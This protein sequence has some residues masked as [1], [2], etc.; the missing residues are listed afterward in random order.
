LQPED[1]E[2]T[3]Q[4]GYSPSLKWLFVRLVLV[5]ASL[6]GTAR[7]LELLNEAFGWGVR[8]PHWTTGRLWLLRVGHAVLT[9]AKVVAADWAWL[10]DHSVQIGP[11]K[12]LVIVGLRLQDLPPA[13]QPLRHTDLE[14]LALVPGQSWT[15]QEVNEQLEAAANITGVPRVIVNDYGGDVH[16]GVALFQA[17]HPQ[18][19]E[20][21]DAKHKAACV[22]KRYLAKNRRWQ[23]FQTLLGQ[24]RCA[25]QQTELAFLVPPAPKPKAR[26]MN[27][28]PTLRWAE[29]VLAILQQPPA[30]VRQQV[31]PERLLEKLGWLQ[32]FAVDVAEWSQWQ[33]VCNSVVAFVDRQGI[34]RGADQALRASFPKL[35]RTSSQQLATELVTFVAEQGQR[36]RAKERLPGSTEVLESCFGRFKQMEKQQAL[37]GFTSLL[38]GFGALLATATVETV[39]G[40]LQ[41]SG[42]RAIFD[43]CKSHLGTTV[44][45]QR[46]LAYASA[47]EPR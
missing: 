4:H 41:H 2:Y 3:G 28:A 47:T 30:P 44:F 9:G 42:T 33:E 21:Y 10:I 32:A 12:C 15:R 13:G 20:L 46:K 22:L 45:A 37:G 1:L 27:L 43:W 5:G 39:K 16:G 35:T 38:L 26:F 7:I 25:I 40:A 17:L 34:Y 19:L 31:R 8:V 23:N 24:T 29:K 18:T 11:E 6:R 36:A 14:L